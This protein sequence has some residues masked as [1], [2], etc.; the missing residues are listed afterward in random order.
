MR[1]DH[2]DQVS[3]GHSNFKANL[4]NLMKLVSK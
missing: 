3:P 2:R 4:N 1:T